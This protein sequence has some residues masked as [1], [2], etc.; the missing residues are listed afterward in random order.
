MSK[1]I[2]TNEVSGLGSAGDVVEVKNGYARNYLLPRGFA[3]LWSKGGEKQVAS[4]R[5]GREARA[6]ATAEEAVALKTAIESATI[7][8]AIKAG[9]GGRLFGA[10]KTADV[11]KAVAAAGFGEIDKRKVSFV[12][13]IRITGSHQASVRLHGDLSAVINLQVVA[14]K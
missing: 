12:A 8:L 14:A 1:L 11:A 5:A 7:K 4:I 3:V 9:A 13:P 2:L 10:V 6:L